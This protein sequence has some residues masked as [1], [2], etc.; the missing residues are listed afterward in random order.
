MKILYVHLGGDLIAGSERS[1][2]DV[3]VAA[4]GAIRAHVLCNSPVMAQAVRS[5]GQEA[6]V[7][8]AMEECSPWT[9]PPWRV[10]AWAAG[11]RAAM[12]CVNKFRPDLI[13]AN[14][15]WVAQIAVPAG[16]LKSRPVVVHVRAKTIRSGRELSLIRLANHVIA[17]S[18]N[19]AGPIRALRPRR[20]EVS[21]VYDP[22]PAPPRGTGIL[23]VR[24]TGVSPVGQGWDGPAT[25]GPDA[26]ATLRLAAAGRLSEEKAF[27]RCIRLLA[28]LRQAG[29]PAELMLYGDGPERPALERLAG[30]LGL[31]PFVRFAGFVA[32][33]PARVAGADAMLLSSRREG[34]GRVIVEAGLAGVPALSVDVDGTGEAMDA[35][36]TGLLVADFESPA[37]RRE[38][39]ALLADRSRLAR[40]GQH[41]R[42]FC[43]ERFDPLGAAEA[44]LRIYRRLV[45]RGA[46]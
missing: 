7:C 30:E 35:G 1:L 23:P 28:H 27:D 12:A 43:R 3:L 46:K 13:H 31:G 24:P 42:A 36:R 34:L 5:I 10:G 18:H 33:L 26:P 19:V 14:S 9:T 40:M 37:C 15:L 11:V 21:V 41:A 4:G 38:I 39:A 45:R 29:L 44:T 6:S 25:H 17:I 20:A 32:D 8:A 22:I 2:L 16:L